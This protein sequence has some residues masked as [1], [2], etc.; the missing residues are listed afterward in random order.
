MKIS[1]K[2]ATGKI[3]APAQ[4]KS[5]PTPLIFSIDPEKMP[6]AGEYDSGLN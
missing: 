5:T 4:Q 1:E 2:G 6:T 3:I